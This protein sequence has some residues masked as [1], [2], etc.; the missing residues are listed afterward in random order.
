MPTLYY[1]FIHHVRNPP[2]SNNFFVFFFLGPLAKMSSYLFQ[3]EKHSFVIFSRRLE[4][5][6][7]SFVY[8]IWTIK[9]RS[10]LKK[11]YFLWTPHLG[12]FFSFYLGGNTCNGVWLYDDVQRV[13]HLIDFD[14]F[15]FFL[16]FWN[17][18]VEQ[19][20]QRNVNKRMSEIGESSS[21]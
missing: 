16:L 3:S 21:G 14:F 7:F 18:Q 10:P 8:L 1:N 6:I 15:L 9:S 2:S 5:I 17:N 19:S 12:F 13:A 20:T 4:F 11:K